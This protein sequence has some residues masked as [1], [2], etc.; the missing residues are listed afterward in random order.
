MAA[1][2]AGRV[3]WA[4]NDGDGMNWRYREIL[5]GG[6]EVEV[7]SVDPESKGV[8]EPRSPLGGSL[9]V[10]SG[11]GSFDVCMHESLHCVLAYCAQIMAPEY[12]RSVGIKRRRG[13]DASF[14]ERTNS[15]STLRP[16]DPEDLGL[17]EL[18]DSSISDET[19]MEMSSIY[20]KLLPAD[21]QPSSRENSRPTSAKASPF[22]KNKDTVNVI[23]DYSPIP[24]NPSET[25]EIARILSEYNESLKEPGVGD[26]VARQF[27]SSI[28]NAPSTAVETRPSKIETTSTTAEPLQILGTQNR[29]GNWLEE[30]LVDT[31][32]LYCVANGVDQ[33]DLTRY[34]D[35]LDSK[36]S[37]QWLRRRDG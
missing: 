28:S 30:L 3:F 18:E 25:S 11:S 23:G 9:K 34:V 8:G 19:L 2:Y 4:T 20:K 5:E 24:N 12:R 1:G 27:D 33:R 17:P 10:G 14:A 31:S 26:P 35:S 21:D 13:V 15:A 7:V 22:P 36:Q 32:L 6:E 16:H 37:L 29:D